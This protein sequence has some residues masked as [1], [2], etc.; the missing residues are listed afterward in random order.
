MQ[1]LEVSH[2]DAMGKAKASHAAA[3][4]KVQTE[5]EAQLGGLTQQLEQLKR[6]VATQLAERAEAELRKL[7]ELEDRYGRV[8]GRCD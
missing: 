1:Q 8:R 6:D 7:K 3:M 2:G 5:A 4:T